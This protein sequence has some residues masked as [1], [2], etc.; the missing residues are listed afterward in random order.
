MNQDRIS[1]SGA[2]GCPCFGEPSEVSP[3]R[4]P[5]VGLDKPSTRTPCAAPPLCLAA[6]Q[7]HSRR[8]LSISECPTS[9]DSHPDAEELRRAPAKPYGGRRR[10][11]EPHHQ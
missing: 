4:R 9:C 1:H 6:F 8:S 7:A 10:N 3:D 11:L 2:K 5:A